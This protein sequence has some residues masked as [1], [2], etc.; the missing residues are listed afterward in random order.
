MPASKPT[1][2]Q[3]RKARAVGQAH[4]AKE[5]MIHDRILERDP[6]ITNDQAWRATMSLPPESR[7][8]RPNRGKR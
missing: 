5:Y 7:G 2:E 6:F 1:E 3:K 8:R 4:T